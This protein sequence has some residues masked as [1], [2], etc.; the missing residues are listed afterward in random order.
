[1]A[2]LMDLERLRREFTEA[3]DR[4]EDAWSSATGSADRR[5]TLAEDVFLRFAVGW[6]EFASEWFIGCVN[7]DAQ[8]LLA[9][10]NRQVLTFYN[11]E[12]D[13]PEHKRLKPHTTPPVVRLPKQPAVS[14]VRKLLDPAEGNIAFP[15]MERMR[16]RSRRELAAGYAQRVQT[17]CNAGGGEIIDAVTAIRNVLAHR[18]Q[19]SVRA[20][21]AC[22]SAFPTYPALRKQSMSRDGIGTYL[23]ARTPSG[24]PRLLIYHRELK[25]VAGLLVP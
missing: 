6:E 15:V 12:I 16:Q 2:N 23:N 5:K 17:V 18:S 10:L 14:T 20:M 7:H 11:T 25:R 3:L 9:Y 22:V 24:E 21:N 8:N 1:V 13:R 4:G 19:R